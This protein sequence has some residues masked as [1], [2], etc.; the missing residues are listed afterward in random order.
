MS[1]VQSEPRLRRINLINTNRCNLRCIYCP[2][3]S[4]PEEYHA[5]LTPEFFEEIYQFTTEHKLEEAGFGYYGE[6]TMIEG[7]WRP[8][9]RLLDAGIKVST[10]TNGATVLSPEEVATFARFKYIEWSI[11][12]H[13]IE[14]LKEVRKKV[15]ARTI[16]HNFHLV[17]SYCLLH[18]LPLPEL[19]WTGVLTIDIIETLPQF[20][21]YAASSGVKKLQFNEVGIYDGAPARTLNIVEQSQETFEW[22]AAQVEKAVELAERF[23]IWINF[24]EMPRIQARKQAIATGEKFGSPLFRSSTPIADVYIHNEAAKLPEGYTR[25]CKTPWEEFYLDPKGQ[26]FSCCARGDVM[27]IAKTKSE[28][29]QVLSNQKFVRLRQSLRTGVDMDPDC[30]NCLLRPSKR[31]PTTGKNP[32]QIALRRLWDRISRV[33]GKSAASAA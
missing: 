25:D 31:L 8:V 26:V 6:L 3:G 22:A 15:D 1:A 10:T 19:A 12:T 33:T 9:R 5:D 20:V 16:A 14:T 17:R 2:Q 11:D 30:A 28:L 24:T 7:W 18:G 32:V 29:E 4:H 27:G 13:D 21:A 23:D